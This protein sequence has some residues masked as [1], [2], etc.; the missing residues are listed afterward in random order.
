MG[1]KVLVLGSHNLARQLVFTNT[2]DRYGS[3]GE[4][5]LLDRDSQQ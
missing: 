4:V 1:E 5:R 2:V 3:H